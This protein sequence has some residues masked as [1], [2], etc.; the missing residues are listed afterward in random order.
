[1][2]LAYLITLLAILRPA[3]IYSLKFHED[4]D[5]FIITSFVH[6]SNVHYANFN[7]LVLILHYD[8]IIN[9]DDFDIRIHIFD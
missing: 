2:L 9:L 8:P 4:Q 5:N 1:M 6:L 7:Y 3:L